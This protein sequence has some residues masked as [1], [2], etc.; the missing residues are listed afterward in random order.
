MLG[1][2]RAARRVEADTRVRQILSDSEHNEAIDAGGCPGR[3]PAGLTSRPEHAIGARMLR[4]PLTERQT[5]VY[6][7]IRSSIRERGIPPTVRELMRDLGV[8]GTNGVSDH[9][10]ALARKGWIVLPPVLATGQGMARGIRLADDDRL[11][12]SDLSAD[13]RS[14]VAA[15]VASIRAS[16]AA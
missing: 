14:R 1:V 15:F 5:Q 4:K 2:P 3:C 9:L 13:E 8:N 7:L 10:K 11:D 16:R 12:V 6:Q